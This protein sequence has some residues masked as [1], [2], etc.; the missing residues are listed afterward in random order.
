MSR[1]TIIPISLNDV[2]SF[3]NIIP[4]LNGIMSSENPEVDLSAVKFINTYCAVN[5]LLAGRTFFRKTGSKL[6]L[7]N[8]PNETAAYLERMDF[9]EKGVFNFSGSSIKSFSRSGMSRSIIEITDIPG[10]EKES[11]KAI[12]SVV[13]L[14][15]KRAD[16]IFKSS[17]SEN[18][19]DN[20]I[21]VISEMCQ[22]I[23]E[24]SLDSG[25]VA[26]Q[27]YKTSKGPVIHLVVSDSGIGI[28]GSFTRMNRNFGRGS[29]LLVKT[30]TMPISSKRDFGYGLCRVNKIVE[31]M[32]GNLYLRSNCDSVAAMNSP[33][34]G[35]M[36]FEKTGLPFFQGTQISFFV[37]DTKS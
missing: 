19:T 33:K 24:H 18:N 28:E 11:I 15:R 34:T 7:T 16:H 35:M 27:T 36:F 1:N 9:L 32:N 20:F 8:V 23:F 30:L 14:F 13:A 3:E 29:D 22:N 6:R 25:Y 2:Y 31:Q 4:A 17:F 12:S 26:L 37:M 21:T 5:L 10:K